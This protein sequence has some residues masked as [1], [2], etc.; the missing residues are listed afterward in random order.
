MPKLIIN[1]AA[2]GVQK[3]AK[4][5]S[6]ILKSTAENKLAYAQ[7]IQ[8]GSL[9]YGEGLIVPGPSLT[10]LTDNSELTGVPIA[11]AYYKNSTEGYITF[12]EGALGNTNRIRRVK[13]VRAGQTPV[14][15][16]DA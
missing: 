11:A 16:T 2:G 1:F 10:A 9:E 6:P 8:S 7:N 4:L 5:G 3:P 12:I 15:D 13:E 14:M